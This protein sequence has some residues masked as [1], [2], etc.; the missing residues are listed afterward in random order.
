MLLKKDNN[1]LL[2]K[3]TNSQ[4][5]N[6]TIPRPICDAS[7]KG[8]ISLFV[9]S[10]TNASFFFKSILF[11]PTNTVKSNYFARNFSVKITTLSELNPYKILLKTPPPS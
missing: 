1:F 8:Q 6:P 4:G 2:H 5:R 3:C 11:T 7:H 9:A 10:K